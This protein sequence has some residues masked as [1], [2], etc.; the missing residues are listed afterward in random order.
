[1]DFI[2]R[3]KELK[4]LGDL[5]VL[6]GLK[7]V[8]V[9]GTKGI[10]KTRLLQEFCRTHEAFYYAVRSGDMTLNERLF[11]SEMGVESGKYRNMYTQ[12]CNKETPDWRTELKWIVERSLQEEIALVFDNADWLM[13]TF[14]NLWQELEMLLN[15]HYKALNLLLIFACRDG[16]LLTRTVEKAFGRQSVT[17]MTLEPLRYMEMLPWFGASFSQTER[18]LLYGVSGGRPARL[19]LFDGGVRG[20]EEIMK[21]C[22]SAEMCNDWGIQALEGAD[23]RIPHMYNRILELVANGLRRPKDIAENMEW[24]SNKLAKYLRVLTE[25]GLLQRVVAAEEKHIKK[26]HKKTFYTIHDTGLLF[27]YRFVF[28]WISLISTGKGKCVWDHVN[29]EIYSSYCEEVFRRICLQHVAILQDRKDLPLTKIDAVGFSWEEV[30]KDEVGKHDY[31]LIKGREECCIGLIF[32]QSTALSAEEFLDAA[33]D[34]FDIGEMQCGKKGQ[35]GIIFVSAGLSE[36]ALRIAS[37]YP[38][39]RCISLQYMK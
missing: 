26:Q 5:F 37:Q 22:F 23:L 10:G 28:P 11:A 16:K 15:Q 9:N 32:W 31:I 20:D 30:Q 17:C 39:I 27:W 3:D 13:K 33:T 21:A 24:E 38:S 29:E 25:T 12:D 8:C 19:N 6:Q 18:V 35:P 14:S 7:I 1:M 4:Q 2:G 34:I 36:G